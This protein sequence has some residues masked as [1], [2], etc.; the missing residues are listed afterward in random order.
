MQ[1]IH[2]FQ[3]LWHITGKT[4]GGSH[5]DHPQINIFQ[6]IGWGAE[7]LSSN[8]LSF[9]LQFGFIWTLFTFPLSF[10]TLMTLDSNILC[11]SRPK[12]YNK[13]CNLGPL[14]LSL[15]SKSKIRCSSFQNLSIY[16][17]LL[18]TC[19]WGLNL[20]CCCTF[21]KLQSE[22]NLLFTLKWIEKFRLLDSTQPPKCENVPFVC[23]NNIY[24]HSETSLTE[25]GTEEKF[26]H[27]LWPRLPP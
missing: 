5:Q 3:S 17:W 9:S 13:M 24:N 26:K 19:P 25:C 6:M 15:Q 10:L 23:Q 22:V 12:T 4:E 18:E 1:I 27:H 2:R 14:T 16:F 8:F 7:Q 11:V 21:H 20:L